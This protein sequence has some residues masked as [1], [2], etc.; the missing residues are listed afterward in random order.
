MTL[1]SLI[2]MSGRG[3]RF[4]QAGYT[5]PKPMIDV[6]GRSMVEL[7]I[8]TLPVSDVYIFVCLQEHLEKY[9]LE[10]LL[11]QATLGKSRIVVVDEVTSGAAASAL[12]AKDL[13]NDD[14]PLLI[15]NVDQ[16]IEYSKK[17]FE[18]LRRYTRDAVDGLI[19]TFHACHPR[20]SFAKL[21][22]QNKIIQVA[23][24]NPI[25]NVATTGHY[26]FRSGRIFVNAAEQMIQ[27]DIRVNGE[28][29]LCPVY[30]EVIL[31]EGVV[32]PFFVDKMFGIGTPE[33]LEDFLRVYR[34]R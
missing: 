12:L 8:S 31:N 5:F 9:N 4:E 26:Y 21:D 10:A 13:I 34:S 3:S 7:V 17:N 32:L 15:S 24:K 6:G 29:Y 16:Y 22:N 25:S 23:E 20:W 14:T 18:I 19:F 11:D 1:R 33:D 27:K 2:L 28:Y 30:N